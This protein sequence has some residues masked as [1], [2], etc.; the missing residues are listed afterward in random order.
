M[1]LR[2][3]GVPGSRVL[4]LISGRVDVRPWGSRFTLRV[5]EGSHTGTCEVITQSASYSL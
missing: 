2:V 3:L 1:R 4:I 5:V